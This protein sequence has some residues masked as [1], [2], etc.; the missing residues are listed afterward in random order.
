MDRLPILIPPTPA[1]LALART[2]A[3]NALADR[4]RDRRRAWYR[5]ENNLEGE[6]ADLYI[7]DEIVSQE[8]VDFCGVGISAQGFVNEL[9]TRYHHVS[10]LDADD[11]RALRHDG[12]KCGRP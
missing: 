1:A 8:E 3:L 5:I 9:Q 10:R 2:E 12:G 6:S 11:P 4:R 7:Y